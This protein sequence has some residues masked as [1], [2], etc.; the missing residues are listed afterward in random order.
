M[1]DRVDFYVLPSQSAQR[2]F[3]VACRLT[4][5]A[6]LQDLSIVVWSA[7]EDGAKSTMSCSGP[8]MI[9]RSCR[10]SSTAAASR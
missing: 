4:A 10:T 3:G 1:T 6:Y 2:R 5:K 9:A 7:D 8:S